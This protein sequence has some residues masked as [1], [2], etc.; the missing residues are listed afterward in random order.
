MKQLYANLRQWWLGFF[1]FRRWPVLVQL[2]KFAVV[3]VSS[4][5]VDMSVYVSL[6]RLAGVYYLL[7]NTVSF[8][9]AVAWSFAWN[10]HWTFRLAGNRGLGGQSGKIL[11]V[12]V[13]GLL[14]ASGLLFVMV[15]TIGL[16]DVLA[17]FL[18]AIVVMF[19]NFSLNKFWTFR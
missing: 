19:W 5:I 2:T 3:G 9:M 1:L 13:G 10:K 7:A 6:T 14:L 17:K 8:L 16:H 11:P 18:I 4:F 12:S 15:D